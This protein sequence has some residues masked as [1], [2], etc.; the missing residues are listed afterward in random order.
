[1][2]ANEAYED[3]AAKLNPNR[4]R[5][6]WHDLKLAIQFSNMYSANYSYAVLRHVDKKYHA[7][8]EHQRWL[9]ER[10][11]LG[12]KAMDKTA[13]TRIEHLPE[14]EKWKEMERL[15]PYFLHPNIQPFSELTEESIHKDAVM[16]ECMMRKFKE[17]NI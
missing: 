3:N 6:G 4:V 10:L 9:T 8:L 17:M 12:Y 13:R 7:E 2:A 11:L 14:S 15:D 5:K 1:M 16:T